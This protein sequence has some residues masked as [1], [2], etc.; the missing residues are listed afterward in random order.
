MLACVY[1]RWGD[2][3]LV[4]KLTALSHQLG[5]VCRNRTDFSSV[6]VVCSQEFIFVIVS[7]ESLAWPRQDNYHQQQSSC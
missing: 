3:D 1:A 7:E 4:A 6:E 2:C 5:H